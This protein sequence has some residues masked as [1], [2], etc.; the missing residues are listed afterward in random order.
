MSD[1]LAT[2][3][4]VARQVSLSMGFPRQ[5]KWDG[6]PFPSPGDLSN[7]G[8]NLVSPALAGRFFTAEPPRKPHQQMYNYYQG[9]CPEKRKM[10]LTAYTHK[11]R[12]DSV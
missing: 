2:P 10:F 4:A 8:I 9:K 11:K 1:S 3:Y 6:P 5:E 7:P 12:I